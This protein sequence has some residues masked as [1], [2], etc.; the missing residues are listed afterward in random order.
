MITSNEFYVEPGIKYVATQNR[1]PRVITVRDLQDA[2]D[3]GS[4]PLQGSTAN[5]D[6]MEA[7]DGYVLCGISSGIS[8]PSGKGRF[9]FRLA[10]ENAFN[11]AY[12]EYTNRLKYYADDIGRNV[13]ISVKYTF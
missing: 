1:A 11:S 8:V 10:V 2:V 7:P 6:F 13:S 12:R 4:D 9:D 3:N 5:F